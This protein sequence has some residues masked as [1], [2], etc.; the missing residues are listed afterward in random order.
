MMAS[1]GFP[2]VTRDA[3]SPFES[4]ERLGAHPETW[5]TEPLDGLQQLLVFECFRWARGGDERI[6]APLVELHQVFMARADEQQRLQALAAIGALGEA[7]A[8]SERTADIG[9]ASLLFLQDSSPRV[10]ATAALQVASLHATE[11]DPLSGARLVFDAALQHDPGRRAAILGGLLTMGDARVAQVLG[12]CWEHLTPESHAV[13]IDVARGLNPT[14]VVVDFFVR[15][16][17][18]SVSGMSEAGIGWISAALIRLAERAESP[19][20]AGGAAGVVQIDRALPVWS[21]EEADV[22]RL[23]E[24]WNREEYGEL[25]A[26]K[27]VA[28]ARRE[29]HPRILPKVLRAWGVPDV[30][31]LE[32]VAMAIAGDGP[33]GVATASF[34]DPVE[35]PILPDWDQPNL[36]LEW[37]VI[38]P[39]GPTMCQWSLVPVEGGRWALVWTRHHFLEP[40]C[41][42]WAVGDFSGSREL[43]EVL[44]RVFEENGAPEVP[45]FKGLVHWVF[46]PDQSVLDHDGAARLLGSAFNAALRARGLEGEHPDA[47]CE[48][49]R[50]MTEDPV[51]EINRQMS[52][53]AERLG[54]A[55]G[56][57]GAGDTARVQ[58][59]L[60]EWHE[61]HRLA[62]P[63]DQAAYRRWLDVASAP[64]HVE[65]V[66]GAFQSAWTEALRRWNGAR[67]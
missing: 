63:P 67:T 30:P 34:A 66:R 58:R 15:W 32:A 10:V 60:D 2:Y 51:A 56:A 55:K 11:A 1:Q 4:V 54:S 65:R 47:A 42:V 14:S 3:G 39:W 35:V 43:L 17:E 21:R 26:P 20:P 16:A 29:T 9:A 27:L 7:L 25:L 61:T 57:V 33:A 12:D 37:G 52:E 49:L 41:V 59:L 13:F 28:I 46:I 36:L 22:V 23:V 6:L 44:S 53:M 18:A 5:D 40:R 8:R 19:L 24:R 50:R 48:A 31:H 62:E 45:L 38:N 64:V